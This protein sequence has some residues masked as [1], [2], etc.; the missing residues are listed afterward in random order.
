M[1]TLQ[2]A[3]IVAGIAVVAAIVIYNKWQEGRHRRHAELVF[4]GTLRDTLLER[5]TES[6]FSAGQDEQ[7]AETDGGGEARS[8]G[9]PMAEDKKSALSR[10]SQKS[11]S[12]PPLPDRLDSRLD[13]CIR[14]EAVEPIDV[15]RLWATQTEIFDD[16]TRTLRWYAFD[17]RANHWRRINANTTGAHHWFLAALQVVDRDG[18]VSEN[19][20]LRYARGMQKL[21][22]HFHAVPAG[23]PSRIEVLG[24]ARAL[25]RFCAEV[26]VQI[27]VNVVSEKA[28]GG[29]RIF[30]L[31]EAEGLRL[32]GDGAFHARASDS[33][34]LY[35]LSNGENPP[36][37]RAT[38]AA[39]QTKHLSLILDLPRVIDAASEFEDMMRFASHIAKTLGASVV[40]DN[41]Q[42]F[43]AES[44]EAIRNRVRRYQM[45][46][47]EEGI[48]P[49]G[50]L[51][52]RL[53]G[54]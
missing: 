50:S 34:T 30:S 7:A 46:M 18:V 51:A 4:P 25:D 33:R 5:D 38:L 27:A 48:P 44:L 49:G 1:D 37:E 19:D 16:V 20:F 28:M 24:N 2:I 39:I 36:F 47:N 53:F 6:G 17:D 29:A 54:T 42:P 14:I 40:D 10:Q 52:R 43:G 26:D 32:E 45:R 31:A 23:I 9:P 13:C 15:P 35:V 12:Q 8:N 11:R 3:L 41:W 22:D 21:A